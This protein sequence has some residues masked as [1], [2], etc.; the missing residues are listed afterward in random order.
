[1]EGLPERRA[2]D[3][4]AIADGREQADNALPVEQPGVFAQRDRLAR[5]IAQR[6]TAGRAHILRHRHEKPARL[7]HRRTGLVHVGH[8]RAVRGAA[9]VTEITTVWTVVGRVIPAQR[10]GTVNRI[11]VGDLARIRRRGQNQVHGAMREPRVSGI[12]QTAARAQEPLSVECQQSRKLAG[13]ADE[14]FRARA[15]SGVFVNVIEVCLR[16]RRP[17]WLKLHA[18][19]TPSEIDGLYDRRSDPA[20]GIDDEIAAL[21]VRLDRPACERREHLGRVPVGCRHVAAVPLPL[22]RLLRTRP[23]GKREISGLSLLFWQLVGVGWRA[24]ATDKGVQTRSCGTSQTEMPR[25]IYDELPLPPEPGRWLARQLRIPEYVRLLRDDEYTFIERGDRYFRGGL[26]RPP[27][28]ALSTA[29]DNWQGR[30]SWAE[31]WARELG[32]MPESLIS[33]PLVAFLLTWRMTLDQLASGVSDRFGSNSLQWEALT[34]ARH[35]AYDRSSSYRVVEFMRNRVQHQ[36]MPPISCS[37]IRSPEGDRPRL[38]VTVPAAW[39]LESSNCPRLLRADLTRSKITTIDMNSVISEA[40]Q[41]FEDVLRA[42]FLVEDTCAP[43]YLEA[44][45]ELAEETAPAAPV[46]AHQWFDENNNPRMIFDPVQSME[47]ATARAAM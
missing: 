37:R 28:A 24:L 12:T 46:V 44:Y 2:H 27:V 43:R 41:A 21:G 5:E 32:P 23:N 4:L 6:T 40:F 42:L 30:F 9:R 13:V 35:R 19:S 29:Y 47:W 15:C 10:L 26:A 14:H 38:A 1:M 36:Q 33:E 25:R 45:Q 8:R 3:Q 11:H 34:T 17:A 7:E 22:A 20:H 31:G 18:D 16:E 39:L